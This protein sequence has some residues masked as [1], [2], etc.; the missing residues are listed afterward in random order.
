MKKI[1]IVAAFCAFLLACLA[2][3]EAAYL[4]ADVVT[5]IAPEADLIT[6]HMYGGVPAGEAIMV[7]NAYVISYDHERRVPKWVAYHITPEYLGNPPREEQFDGYGDDPELDIEALDGEYDGVG[8]DRGH[9]VPFAVSGGDRNG[10]GLTAIIDADGDGEFDLDADGDFVIS[11]PDDAETVFQINYM[12]NIAPQ[13]GLGFNRS[14]G[15]WRRLEDCIQDHFV[16]RLNK[17]VWVIAGSLFFQGEIERIGD[18][19]NIFVPNFYYKIVVVPVEGVLSDVKVLAFLF[20]HQRE[21]SRQISQFLVSVDLIEQLT[22]L[23]F[24]AAPDDGISE[25]NEAIDTSLNWPDI[26]SLLPANTI[27]VRN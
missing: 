11:D 9:L 24:F 23:N 1:T 22:G 27:C 5:L 19:N 18:D 14:P 3:S 20:P 15:L 10:N 26:V 13:H 16:E 2:S 12:S 4:I 21:S 8:Y 6:E 7:R 25:V 17:E